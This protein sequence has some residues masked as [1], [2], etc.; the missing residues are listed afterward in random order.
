[1]PGVIRAA[2]YS[3][4]VKNILHHPLIRDM[5]DSLPLGVDCTSW[6]FQRQA[7]QY[8]EDNGLALH[9]LGTVSEA[10]GILYAKRMKGQSWKKG[11]DGDQIV[12]AS[13]LPEDVRRRFGLIGYPPPTADQM[14]AVLGW[15]EDTADGVIVMPKNPWEFVSSLEARGEGR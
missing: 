8:A 10:I 5:A 1:M 15:Y 12:R 6:E 11:W 4:A 3:Q 14:L 9:A 2:H 13:A 7:N